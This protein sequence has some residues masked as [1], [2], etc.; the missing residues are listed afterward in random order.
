MLGSYDN[1]SMLSCLELHSD[2][3][4][5]FIPS[6]PNTYGKVLGI[7]FSILYFV[8]ANTYFAFINKKV[9]LNIFV[10]II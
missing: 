7:L 10:T 9:V 2:T 1:K 8:A 4:V 3:R 5:K 6:L